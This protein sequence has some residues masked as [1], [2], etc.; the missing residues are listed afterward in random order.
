MELVKIGGVTINLENVT[1]IVE[2]HGDYKPPG[3]R[4]SQS[5]SH[6]LVRFV[7][8]GELPIGGDGVEALREFIRQRGTTLVPT[9]NDVKAAT[10]QDQASA[11]GGDA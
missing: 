1:A 6:L 2:A 8:G 5:G 7:G 9:P 10:G 11:S 4:V 3:V